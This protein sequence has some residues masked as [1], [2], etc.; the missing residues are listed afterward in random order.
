LGTGLLTPT[1]E[2]DSLIYLSENTAILS[3]ISAPLYRDTSP[4]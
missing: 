3:D 2:R 1:V 4:V